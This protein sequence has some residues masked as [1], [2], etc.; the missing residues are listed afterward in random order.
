MK[1][2]LLTTLFT[3]FL[4][5]TAKAKDITIVLGDNIPPYAIQDKDSGAEVEIF[6][7]A[8]KTQGDTV[9]FK[10]VPLGRVSEIV[11][12]LENKDY[13]DIDGADRNYN[14]KHQEWF[15][16][17]YIKYEGCIITPSDMPKFESRK[18]LFS[19]DKIHKILA[20]QGAHISFDDDFKQIT[21]DYKTKYEEVNEQKKQAVALGKKDGTAVVADVHIIRY[22]MEN[23]PALKEYKNVKIECNLNLPNNTYKA[24]FRD[25]KVRDAFN[26]GL[27]KI[28]ADGTYEKIIKKYDLAIFKPE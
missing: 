16:I 24:Y 20:F 11:D 2:I 15:S 21:L 12:D 7:E 25:P 17:P 14:P 8:F 9:K 1:K 23:D 19:S 6:R 26:T 22:K 27:K 4:T 28:V 13:K 18:A 10:Y 5:F 3:S